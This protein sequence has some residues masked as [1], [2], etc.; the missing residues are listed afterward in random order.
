MT[1][2]PKIN[3]I[4]MHLLWETNVDKYGANMTQILCLSSSNAVKCLQI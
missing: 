4:M 2:V 3:R 1:F